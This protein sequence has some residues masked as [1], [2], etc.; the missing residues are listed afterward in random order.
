MQDI[1]TIYFV[2]FIWTNRLGIADIDEEV[3]LRTERIEVLAESTREERGI[4]RDEGLP[5]L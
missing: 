2:V 1:K 4:L 3:R 5:W